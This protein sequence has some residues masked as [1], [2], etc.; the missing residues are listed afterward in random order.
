MVKGRGRPLRRLVT[1]ETLATICKAHLVDSVHG[2]HFKEEINGA[3]FSDFHHAV[4]RPHCP[5]LDWRRASS[6]R[7]CG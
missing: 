6:D 2:Q 5:L 7:K 3:A 1:Y 4:G